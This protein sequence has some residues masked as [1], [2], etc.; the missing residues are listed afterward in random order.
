[1]FDF[2]RRRDPLEALAEWKPPRLKPPVTPAVSALSDA[3]RL[4]Y[5]ITRQAIDHD[6]YS[7]QFRPSTA[8]ELTGER[9][10][11]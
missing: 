9:R 8:G 3:D 6:L 1:M 11:Y 7:T 10:G 4:G 2:W 5:A